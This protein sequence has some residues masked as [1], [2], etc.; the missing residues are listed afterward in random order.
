MYV[1]WLLANRP[2]AGLF[3]INLRAFLIVL[4]LV[5]RRWIIGLNCLGL[6]LR[7]S[8]RI[9]LL[10]VRQLWDVVEGRSRLDALLILV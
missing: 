5:N 3:T 8:S 2:A 9:L 4:L 6:L 7:L 10:L 1:P